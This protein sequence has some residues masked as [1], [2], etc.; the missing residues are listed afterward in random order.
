MQN[1][2]NV[3]LK[4]FFDFDVFLR[5]KIINDC[6]SYLLL[7]QKTIYILQWEIY[8]ALQCPFFRLSEVFFFR[9]FNILRENM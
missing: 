6:L 1:V 9:R 2:S 3:E 7:I 5:N 4:N 8:H